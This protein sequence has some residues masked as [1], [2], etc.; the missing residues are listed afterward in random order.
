MVARDGT[1]DSNNAMAKNSGIINGGNAIGYTISNKAPA[2]HGKMAGKGTTEISNAK[3]SNSITA[4]NIV[5]AGYSA[6]VGDTMVACDNRVASNFA[7]S[8]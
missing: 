8:G 4:G 2:N 5:E 6:T 7:A 3:A 1:A